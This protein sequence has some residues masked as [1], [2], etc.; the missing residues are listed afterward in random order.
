MLENGDSFGKVLDVMNFGAGD[1]LEIRPAAGGE[2]LLLPFTK[3]V[4]PVVD[5]AAGFVTVLPPAELL[6]A[7]EAD[8]E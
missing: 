1:I 7:E 2:A 8:A 5:V 6:V 4:V 3:A